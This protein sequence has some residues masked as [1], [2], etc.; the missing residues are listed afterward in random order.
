MRRGFLPTGIDA[1]DAAL[2]VPGRRSSRFCQS[3]GIH[4]RVLDHGAIHVGDPQ[5]P[6]GPGLDRRGPEP[7]VAGGQELRLLLVV[8]AAAGEGDALAA[9]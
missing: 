8:G 4:S 9:S 1:I 2:V 5:R 6:V 3:F 7:V